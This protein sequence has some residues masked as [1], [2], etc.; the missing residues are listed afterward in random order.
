M[1]VHDVDVDK[2][3]GAD[4]LQ[5]GLKVHEVGGQNAG[6][7]ALRGHGTILRAGIRCADPAFWHLIDPRKVPDCVLGGE[8]EGGWCE[9]GGAGLPHADPSALHDEREH[10]AP[11]PAPEAFPRRRCPAT[12]ATTCTSTT[13]ASDI[14]AAAP[15]LCR[16]LSC[17]PHSAPNWCEI[18]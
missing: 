15:I 17:A 11:D 5:L 13:A 9:W 3:R 6:V 16:D 2:I 18:A 12:T 1:V 10:R 4:R 8:C 7:H 14:S